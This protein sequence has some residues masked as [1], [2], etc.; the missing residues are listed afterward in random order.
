MGQQAEMGMRVKVMAQWL[1]C[2]NLKE[3][4]CRKVREIP[5]QREWVV[6]MKEHKQPFVL[7]VTEDQMRACM[8]ATAF[9]ATAKAALLLF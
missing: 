9:Y 8:S 7:F 1:R 4:E 5:M 2:S 3:M 6:E